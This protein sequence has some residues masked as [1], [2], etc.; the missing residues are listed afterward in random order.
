[1]YT[2]GQVL[3]VVLSKKSQVY[4]MQV[5]EVI[6]KKTLK[7]EE[8]RYLLQGGTDKTSTVFLDEVDGE[9]F[10]SAEM[11]RD[12]LVRRATAQVNRLVDT[13]VQKSKEWYA[14]RDPQTIQGLPDLAPPRST[15]QLEVVRDDDERATV[16]LPDGTVAKIKI[17]SV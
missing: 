7:G 9:V 3:F 5:V 16:V 2:I 6:T 1:M 17:P 11:T 4:P 8:T 10:D 15:P 13:A 14:G 12:I